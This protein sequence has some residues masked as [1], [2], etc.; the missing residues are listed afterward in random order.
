MNGVDYS[1]AIGGEVVRSGARCGAGAESGDA[2]ERRG[3][4]CGRGGEERGAG[5]AGELDRR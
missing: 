4:W 5:R 3:R 1:A 2:G